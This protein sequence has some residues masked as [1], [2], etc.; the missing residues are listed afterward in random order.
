M[1]S[2]MKKRNFPTILSWWI[3]FDNLKISEIIFA[4]KVFKF[5]YYFLREK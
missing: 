3:L 5:N 1:I 4:Y 2:T